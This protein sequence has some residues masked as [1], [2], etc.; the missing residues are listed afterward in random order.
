[1]VSGKRLAVKGYSFVDYATQG[2]NLVV[3]LLIA[4]FH[5]ITV[6]HWPWLLASHAALAIVVHGLVRL[7]G[8][9]PTGSIS[10][11]VSHFYPVLLYAFFFW[12]TGEINRMFTTE[13]LDPVAIRWEQALFGWQP[14]VQLM[15]KLPYGPISELFYAAYFSYYI[16]IGGVGLALFWR[17]RGQFFHFVS[18]VSFVFYICYLI[19]IFLPIIGPRVFFHEIGG[20]A[21]PAEVQGLATSDTYPPQVQSGLFFHLMAIIYRVFESPGAAMPSSHVAVALCT[22]FFSFRYLRGI[23]WFHLIVAELLC[24]ATVYCRYHYVLD[25]LGGLLVAA[26][27]IPLANRLYFRFSPHLRTADN[28]CI[29]CPQSPRESG[30]S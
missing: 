9:S 23:R 18:V 29:S 14:S 21:L 15:E 13:Y 3:A 5:N 22:V 12:E 24:V 26:I 7:R 11:F 17:D 1:V 28:A 2:Y 20:Y 16:M 6:R 27:L 30:T 25:V 19:Y 4:G 8:C 10:G